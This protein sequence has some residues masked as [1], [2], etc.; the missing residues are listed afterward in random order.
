M[1]AYWPQAQDSPEEE[2]YIYEEII[3]YV[4]FQS[5]SF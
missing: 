5:P 4:H 2:W 3:P 1:T